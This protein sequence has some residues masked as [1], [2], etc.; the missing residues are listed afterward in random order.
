[1]D[2]SWFIWNFSEMNENMIVKAVND[3]MGKTKNIYVFFFIKQGYPKLQ[4][5]VS[6]CFFAVRPS[7]HMISILD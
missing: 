3:D 6:L 5:I 2:G 4:C 7:I 1:M